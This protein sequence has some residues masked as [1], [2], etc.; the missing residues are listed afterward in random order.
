[1]FDN[2]LPVYPLYGFI[3]EAKILNIYEEGAIYKHA[4]YVEGQSKT[5]QIDTNNNSAVSARFEHPLLSVRNPPGA[6]T[7]KQTQTHTQ[8][9]K[10]SN[11]DGIQGLFKT[12]TSL[13]TW[14]CS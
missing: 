7:N 6:Q 9:E 2:S 5:L 11:A 14:T 12:Q 4:I 3:L 8:L 10:S 13:A 1:M